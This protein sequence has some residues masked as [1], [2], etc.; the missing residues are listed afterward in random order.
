MC[1]IH[2]WTHQEDLL[3]R[4]FL[5]FRNI[6]SENSEL[7][8]EFFTDSLRLDNYVDVSTDWAKVMGTSES[9]QYWN[10]H[11]LK[12][13]FDVRTNF[14]TNPYVSDFRCTLKEESQI[15]SDKAILKL[16]E[17]VSILFI[18]KRFYIIMFV[19]NQN[20]D[21]I[22][23]QNKKLVYNSFKFHKTM[24]RLFCFRETREHLTDF[25]Q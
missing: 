4:N 8:R 14:K 24:V 23:M 9:Q 6:V 18:R 21:H 7:L 15:L 2:T 20:T 12:S 10:L 22:S 17:F 13:S 1:A 19:L 25:K 3:F 16:L 5:Q 11:D